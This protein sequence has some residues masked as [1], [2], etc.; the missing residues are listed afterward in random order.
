[1]LVLL[2]GVGLDTEIVTLGSISCYSTFL[3]RGLEVLELGPEPDSLQMAFF[4]SF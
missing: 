4:G 3:I 1:V 2:L